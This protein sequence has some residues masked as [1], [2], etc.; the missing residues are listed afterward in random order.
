MAETRYVPRM[1]TFYDEVVRA[2][3]TEQFSYKNPMQVPGI[4]RW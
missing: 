1:R 2:K 4:D 3:L